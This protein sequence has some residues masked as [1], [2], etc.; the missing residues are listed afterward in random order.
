MAPI[1]DALA[2]LKSLKPG[3]SINFTQI[4]KKYG[5]NRS[6]LS[7]RWRG[8]S[9]TVAERVKN[10]Q[11]L[12]N[13]QELQLIE[14]IKTLYNQGLPPTRAIISNF[15]SEIASKQVGKNWIKRFLKRHLNKL[16]SR[17]ATGIDTN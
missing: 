5:V 10:T 14:Y 12:N 13:A 8:K 3:E 4:A 7:R 9:G 2:D 1:D 6:T 17:W 11:L 15:A 16:I